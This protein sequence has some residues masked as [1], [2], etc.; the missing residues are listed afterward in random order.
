MK[1][2]RFHHFGLS[3]SFV[4]FHFCHL[5]LSLCHISLLLLSFFTFTSLL[6]PLTLTFTFSPFTFMFPIK[7]EVLRLL[8][9]QSNPGAQSNLVP[10]KCNWTLP[11]KWKIINL[12]PVVLSKCS[13]C[14]QRERKASALHLFSECPHIWRSIGFSIYTF[15]EYTYTYTCIIIHFSGAKSGP[16][17]VLFYVEPQES[18]S[19]AGSAG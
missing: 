5:S 19:Q 3:C 4:N 18:Q 1:Q 6:S 16:L 12:Q 8:W 13:Q 11:C 10:L 2:I 17:S 15:I 7:I 14:F 9:N